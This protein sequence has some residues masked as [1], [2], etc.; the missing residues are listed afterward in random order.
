MPTLNPM[1][2]LPRFPHIAEQIFACMEDK[3]LKNSR[4]VS[5]SWLNYVDNQNFL[6]NKIVQ[7]EG[8]NKAFQKACENGHLKMVEMLI[9]KSTKFNIDFNAKDEHGSTSFHY[10]CEKGDSKIAEMLIQKSSE[11]NIDL[12][13]RHEDGK[14]AFQNACKY[15]HSKIAEMLIQ[16]S[17]EFNIDL[18]AKD[19]DG[20]TAFHNAY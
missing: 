6:W 18:N 12:N 17:S 15:G 11:F 1:I 14:T 3:S 13:A 9:Q 5:K 16:K 20:M 10:A 2:F 8:G 4:Q 7:K 19:E